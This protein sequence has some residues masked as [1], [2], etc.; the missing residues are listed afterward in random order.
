MLL[1]WMLPDASTV[2]SKVDVQFPRRTSSCLPCLQCEGEICVS[3]YSNPQC[4]QLAQR[5]TDPARGGA[6]GGQRLEQGGFL[7]AVLRA[8]R[9]KISHGELRRKRLGELRRWWGPPRVSGL[10]QKPGW[11]GCQRRRSTP[12]SRFLSPAPCAPTVPRASG[13]WSRWSSRR[14]FP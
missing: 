4:R 14:L 8:Q 11:T 1:G 2:Q 7:C 10:A 5:G 12:R 3:P 6:A 9:L 13:L